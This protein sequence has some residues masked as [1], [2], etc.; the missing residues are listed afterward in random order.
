MQS[1]LITLCTYET[2]LTARCPKDITVIDVY[3]VTIESRD[4]ISAEDILASLGKYRD[5]ATRYQEEITEAIAVDLGPNTRVTT[6][7]IHSGIVTTCVVG[8]L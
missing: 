3:T 2:S 5:A 6:V 1:D 8:G 7:G 4:M